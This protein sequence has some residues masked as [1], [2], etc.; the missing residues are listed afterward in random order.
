MR[1]QISSFFSFRLKFISLLFSNKT[2]LEYSHLVGMKIIHTKF[3][4]T[5]VRIWSDLIRSKKPIFFNLINV[6]D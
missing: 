6:I 4:L 1:F 3:F 2:D 5:R